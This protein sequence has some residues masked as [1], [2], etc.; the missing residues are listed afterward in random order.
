MRKIILQLKLKTAYQILVE[1]CEGKMQCY[2]FP[3]EDNIHN[4][5]FE[6]INFYERHCP[7]SKCKYVNNIDVIDR[8]GERH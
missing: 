6:D 7:G 2:S 4:C 8:H 1:K 5:R 3:E